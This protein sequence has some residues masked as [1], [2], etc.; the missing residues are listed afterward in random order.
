MLLMASVMMLSDQSHL[1]LETVALKPSSGSLYSLNMLLD[2]N[3][4]G[5][6]EAGDRLEPIQR[7]SLL[8]LVTVCRAIL[9]IVNA[10]EQTPY[11]CRLP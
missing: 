6:I 1:S 5:R 9:L 2:K 4:Q 10:I 7:R 8:F 3:P 11:R